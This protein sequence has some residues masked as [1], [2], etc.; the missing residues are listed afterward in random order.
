MIPAAAGFSLAKTGLFPPAGSR[1][2]SQI[3]LNITLPSLLFSKVVPSFNQENVKA[4]GPI[5]LVGII[6]MSISAVAAGLIRVFAPTPRNFRYGLIAASIWS[7][8]GECLLL[9]F[10][11]RFAFQDESTSVGLTDVLTCL[12]AV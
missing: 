1:S 11:L 3:I 5:F 6:Y 2:A 7:N 8:W 10:R 9:G 12:C 4:I